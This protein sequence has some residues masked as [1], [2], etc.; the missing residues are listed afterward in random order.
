MGLYIPTTK[1]REI[2]RVMGDLEVGG[3]VQP[4]NSQLE[5]MYRHSLIIDPSLGMYWETLTSLDIYTYCQSVLTV[6]QQCKQ[7]KSVNRLIHSCIALHCM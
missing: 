2:F 1:T 6:L 4:N 7:C 5:A 3:E